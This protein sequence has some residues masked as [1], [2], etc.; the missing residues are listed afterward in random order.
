MLIDYKILSAGCQFNN[1]E[2]FDKVFLHAVSVRG[3]KEVQRF[4]GEQTMPKLLVACNGSKKTE[5]YNRNDVILWVRDTFICEYTYFIIDRQCSSLPSGSDA[6]QTKMGEQNT[7]PLTLS[8]N[9]AS[10]VAR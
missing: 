1:A 7:I 6:A 8:N 5:W 10:R 2:E 9:S 4:V 3:V